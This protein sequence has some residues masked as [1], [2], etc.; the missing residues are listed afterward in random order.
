[1][2]AADIKCEDLQDANERLKNAIRMGYGK[3][4]AEQRDGVWFLVLEPLHA[5][6]LHDG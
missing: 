2:S 5:H 4:K 1:M 3:A 6:P